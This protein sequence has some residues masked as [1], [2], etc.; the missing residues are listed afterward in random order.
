[1]SRKLSN[2]FIFQ[3]RFNYFREYIPDTASEDA[4]EFYNEIKAL[5]QEYAEN[6]TGKK[7]AKSLIKGISPEPSLMDK[8]LKVYRGCPG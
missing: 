8:I 3:Q 5:L 1:M 6:H 2:H 7:K 4:I